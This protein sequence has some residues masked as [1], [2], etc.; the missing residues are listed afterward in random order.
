MRLLS[1]ALTAI[2]ISVIAVPPQ[3][4]SQDD[5]D[6]TG[7][8]QPG[9]LFGGI[10]FGELSD[11]QEESVAWSAKYMATGQQGRLQIEA[12]VGRSWHIYSTT[13]AS[14]GPLPTKFSIASPKTVSIAGKFEPDE[15]PTKS[16]SDLYPGITIEEHEGI[17]LWTAPIKVPDGFEGPIKVA[18]SA[19][20]CQTG[21]S[22]MPSDET[23]TATY[24]GPLADDDTATEKSTS[25]SSTTQP[26]ASKTVAGLL[27][28]S[29]A[30]P[31]T[32]RDG[33]YEVTWTAGV[34]SSIAP[35]GQGYL[36]FRAKPA[37]DY[38]VYQGVTDDSESSTNFVITQK[39]G[40]M[41]GEPET[42]QPL[43]TSSLPEIP[44]LPPT[45]P[46]KYHKGQVTWVLPVKVPADLAP[47]NYDIGG[48]VCY[49][50]C[51]DKS[52]LPPM[53]ME[54]S[55]TVMVTDKTDPTIQPLQ[56][57]AAKF[58]MAIDKAAETDWVD[59]LKPEKTTVPPPS[60]DTALPK[61]APDK[62]ESNS[63]DSKKDSADDED[64]ASAV[65]IVP[66]DA[67]KASLPL[68]F[69]FA[70][71]G[72]FILNFMPCV[73]PVIG[74]KVLSFAKQAGEDRRRVAM[75]NFAYVAGIMAVFAVLAV[76]VAF[77]SLGWG[78]QFGFFEVRLA[79]TVMVFA[80]ALSYLGVW[81]LPTPGVATGKASDE[82]QKKEG[83]PGAFF[84]GAFATMLAT[85][86][87]GPFL[88][89][90]MGYTLY[91]DPIPSAAVIMT[92][93]LG[94]SIPYLLLGLFPSATKLLPK[95]GNWMVTLK[96]LMAFL[97]LGTVAFFFNQFNDG[98]K[99]PVF[100]TLI[101]VWF[102]C[103]VVGKVPPWESFQKRMRGWII[104]LASAAAVGWLAFAYLERETERT[105]VA[106]EH[107]RWEEY[108][109]VKLQN[110]LA[111]G[112]TVMLDFTA[113]W[114]WNCKTNTAVALDTVRTKEL[115]EELDVVPM[116]ADY[117]NFDAHI[118]A[119][120]TELGSISIPILA[121]YPG[122]AAERPIVLRDIVT[123]SMVLEAL[124][125]AGPSAGASPKTS[126]ASVER[127]T[128]AKAA[129]S[130]SVV[131]QSH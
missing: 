60:A 8:D 11:G 89:V 118:K 4:T 123:Q 36:I 108:D 10:S 5:F 69:L 49:Q 97:F 34:S 26:S 39:S 85:P 102:G 100:V 130:D 71:C 7:F 109:E 79:L 30:K 47:G 25:T 78:E 13:Q 12:T 42:D 117:T 64:P 46:I 59:D 99:L 3:A 101:G 52:C 76:L 106:D 16:V 15:P 17:I 122:Q 63:S 40:L 107:I 73:L 111:S 104:G 81:E 90:A 112:K 1:A 55:A 31:T 19:L 29:A 124:K 92:V 105:L 126:V 33:D 82:L 95:P 58:A 128:S 14:G 77:F 61:A 23:L 70:L 84:T 94:M 62:T 72:G 28:D 32:Y 20:V 127:L 22:C 68:I 9:N 38:H 119:K 37:D 131:V 54:F 27:A 43:M 87:S 114:C 65:A 24:A 35:G 103:W 18:V 120:L 2:L 66:D 6:P 21:G 67:S 80:L 110:Y 121:I 113:E 125:Q 129:V 83:L 74:I 45:P 116:L 53:A 91:L 44:G 75:L 98:Q 115:V 96:E 48:F 57:K 88:G 56:I 50:A 86:C 51:T 93:G 41:V